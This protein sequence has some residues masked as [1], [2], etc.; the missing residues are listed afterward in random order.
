MSWRFGICPTP[1]RPYM[2]PISAFH[3]A[4]RTTG[5]NRTQ[6]TLRR[7]LRAVVAISVV[8][9]LVSL[10]IR[11]LASRAQLREQAAEL[12]RLRAETGQLDATDLR[13]FEVLVVPTSNEKIWM[14]K[15]ALPP[16]TQW[17]LCVRE[18]IIPSTGLHDTP[19]MTSF[20]YV[21]GG[22]LV[23]D[24]HYRNATRAANG[25][26]ASFERTDSTVPVPQTRYPHTHDGVAPELFAVRGASL[27]NWDSRKMRSSIRPGGSNCY[28]FVLTPESSISGDGP[29]RF[30]SSTEPAAGVLIWLEPAPRRRR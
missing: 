1:G 17:R 2:A 28:E 3:S 22:Q 12:A 10:S 8:C 20:G 24:G 5:P 27:L 15:I 9:A 14:W 18:G 25:W 6:F 19:S 21:D 4:E 16:Q 11:N 13:K 23:L 7:M 26:S 29:Q 30:D